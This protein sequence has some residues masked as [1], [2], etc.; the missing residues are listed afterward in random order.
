MLFGKKKSNGLFSEVDD[1]RQI[2]YDFRRRTN[3]LFENYRAV[4]YKKHPDYDL[5]QL[6]K[7]DVEVLDKLFTAHAV[8][9]GNRD[10][11]VESIL[12]PVRDGIRYL[13]DQS[14]EHMDFYARQGGNIVAHSLDIGR[15]LE[16]WKA[17]EAAMLKEHEHTQK[18]WNRYC[19]YDQK[20][21]KSYER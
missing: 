11:L 10:C 7:K 1:S 5:E 16:F 19:G 15:I 12:G 8:D 6:K 17:K 3:K 4:S 14:L 21:V 13:D 18:L 9:A 20:E 2:V